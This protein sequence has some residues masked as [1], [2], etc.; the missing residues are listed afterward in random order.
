M[1][2]Y[3]TNYART[4]IKTDTP[5]KF[6]GG[7]R[8][9]MDFIRFPPLP[10]TNNCFIYKI[11]VFSTLHNIFQDNA[12]RKMHHTAHLKSLLM[13]LSRTYRTD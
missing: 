6:S 5:A 8:K 10:A 3:Q 9:S 7:Q 11:Y 12:L 4:K 2:T 13:N 1:Y